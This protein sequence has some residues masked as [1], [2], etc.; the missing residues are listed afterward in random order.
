MSLYAMTRLLA[1]SGASM[2]AGE[3]RR[4]GARLDPLELG[5]HRLPALPSGSLDAG[6][7]D[8]REPIGDTAVAGTEPRRQLFERPADG[9]R[10]EHLFVHVLAHLD[11][12]PLLR[13]RMQL[14][15]ELAPAVRLEHRTVRGRRAIE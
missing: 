13:Q 8:D 6:V 9:E 10:I 11:P 1:G 15:L 14:L 3:A 4:G 2:R 12:A 5:E 7:A